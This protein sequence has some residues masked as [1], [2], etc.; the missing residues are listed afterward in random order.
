[1]IKGL[2]IYGAGQ[3]KGFD[4]PT[5]NLSSDDENLESGIYAATAV[6]DQTTYQGICFI[7]R[8]WLLSDEA[9]RIEMHL[10]DYAGADFY[11]KEIEIHLKKKLRDPVQFKDEE[12]AKQVIAQ[13]ILQA[14][15]YFETN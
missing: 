3:A 9:E 15:N 6:L 1:M 2:V 7:G 14:K 4:V 13:D 11:G 10:F 12:E 5:A 8:A